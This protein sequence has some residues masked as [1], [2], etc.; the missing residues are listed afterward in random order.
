[1]LRNR[2]CIIEGGMSQLTQ[3]E[4]NNLYDR[5]AKFAEGVARRQ[6]PHDE[7]QQLEGA[8]IALNK[9]EDSAGFKQVGDRLVYDPQIENI[10][11]W[12]KTTIVNAIK[13]YRKAKKSV[14]SIPL[15]YKELSDDTVDGFHGYEVK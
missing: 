11:A 1:M 15:P 8:D 6:F 14:K 2:L 10:M 5:L 3:V 9:F 7:S 12:G 13:D 4:Y